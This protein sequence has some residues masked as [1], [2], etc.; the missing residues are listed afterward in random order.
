MN[1]LSWIQ[2][3]GN[4]FIKYPF[5]INC[6]GP[7]FFLVW[8]KKTVKRQLRALKCLQKYMFQRAPFGIIY[9]RKKHERHDK[10]HIFFLEKVRFYFLF[11]V[12]TKYGPFSER[13]YSS[14]FSKVFTFLSF[15]G[16]NVRQLWQKKENSKKVREIILGNKIKLASQ[17]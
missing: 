12:M 4:Q 15:C 14:T 17:K 5:E 9:Y 6:S 3:I 8:T 7:L 1:V 2:H 11:E 16:K 13:P 10:R